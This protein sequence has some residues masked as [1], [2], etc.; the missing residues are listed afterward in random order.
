VSDRPRSNTPSFPAALRGAVNAR[1]LDV[2]TAMPARVESYDAEQ[3]RVS[4]KPLIKRGYL[5]E[6][7]DRQTEEIPVINDVPVVFPGA[8]GFRVTFP[9]ARGDV[10]LIVF[11]ET[12]L[13]RWLVRGSV[14]D[15][16]DDRR[17][18]LNDAIAIP[19]LRPFSD[20]LASAPTDKLS[21]GADEGAVINIATDDIEAR[22]GTVRL[23]EDPVTAPGPLNE[24][25]LTGQAIDPFTGQKHALLGNA[26]G[27]VFAKK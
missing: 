25:V 11:A 8:G 4:V 18:D 7:G 23:G 24:G 3:Q 5:D 21:I 27:K 17:H 13:D 6:A 2:H 1:L 12:S 26:S 20:P 10:V 14:I 16:G 22:A 19:G 15:P 9:V